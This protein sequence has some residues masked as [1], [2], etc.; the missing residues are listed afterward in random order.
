MARMF[1]TMQGY[2]NI[3]ANH[4]PL[5]KR[6]YA[7]VTPNEMAIFKD[8]SDSKDPSIS[9]ALQYAV[10]RPKKIHEDR[11]GFD[12]VTRDDSYAFQQP[13]FVFHFLSHVRCYFSFSCFVFTGLGLSM[14][15]LT[16]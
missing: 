13:E 1:I 3:K 7:V 4:S 9:I 8:V 2:I 12:V 14:N 6:V 5:W 16:T 10:V 11:D 15:G